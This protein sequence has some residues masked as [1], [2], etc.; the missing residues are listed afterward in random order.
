MPTP[1]FEA[2]ARSGAGVQQ[3]ADLIESALEEHI[4][5]GAT[6]VSLGEYQGMSLGSFTLG[7]GFLPAGTTLPALQEVEDRYERAGWNV[8]IGND[9]RD[10]LGIV[11]NA[12]GPA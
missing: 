12:E 9:Q 4:A 10:G 5:R 7:T 11:I 1:A 3:Q 6:K 2:L 8:R